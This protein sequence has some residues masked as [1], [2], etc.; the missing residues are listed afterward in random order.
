MR[1][2]LKKIGSD[3]RHTFTAIV[4]KFSLK[5]GYRGLPLRTILL[6]SVRCEGKEVCGTTCAFAEGDSES[7]CYFRSGKGFYYLSGKVGLDTMEAVV[8]SMLGGE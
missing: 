5:S 3:E 1:K 7:A 2:E 6:T 4:E 8:A